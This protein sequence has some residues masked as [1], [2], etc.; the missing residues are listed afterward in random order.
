MSSLW[1]LT[2]DALST[3]IEVRKQLWWITWHLLILYTFDVVGWIHRECSTGQLITARPQRKQLKLS[4]LFL[5]WFYFPANPT[6]TPDYNPSCLHARVETVL[7]KTAH[8]VA[9]G[10]KPL[11]IPLIFM[12]WDEPQQHWC[13]KLGIEKKYAEQK[14]DCDSW[15]GCKTVLVSVSSRG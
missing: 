8:A 4:D 11:L 5:S 14:L 6:L 3:F 1:I 12:C 9:S 7:S 10:G 15:S 13:S 2:K